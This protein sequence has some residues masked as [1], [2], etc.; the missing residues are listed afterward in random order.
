[1][2]LLGIDYGKKRIG[3]AVAIKGIITPLDVIRNDSATISKIVT[4]IAENHIDEVYVGLSEG[5]LRPLIL[6]FVASLQCVIK[7]KVKTV[8]ESVSTI[9]AEEIY[10]TNRNPKKDYKKKIDS[11]AA[12]VILRRVLI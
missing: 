12:A 10:K 9:E 5:H 4:V 1:M 11:I 8:E 6:N 3:L 7:L 2:N